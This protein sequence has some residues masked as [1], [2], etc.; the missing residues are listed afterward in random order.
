MLLAQVSTLVLSS[1]PARSSLFGLRVP[2]SGLPAPAVLR[3]RGLISD[4]VLY[5]LKAP[6]C[7]GFIFMY[8]YIIYIFFY[9]YL[10]I[11]RE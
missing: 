2:L 9:V 11:L 10:L 3:P 5:S 7:A 8:V 1:W 4:L 6:A